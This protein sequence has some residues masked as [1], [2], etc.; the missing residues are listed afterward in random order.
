MSNESIILYDKTGNPSILSYRL[1]FSGRRSLGVTVEKGGLVKVRAPYGFP[2]S[3]IEAFL[4]EKADWLL[5]HILKQ[6]EIEAL[7]HQTEL[8]DTEKTKL[9]KRYRQAAKDYI[10]KR[11]AFFAEKMGLSYGKVFIR[12]QRSQWGS[13]SAEKNLSFNWR[14]MLSPPRIIDYVIVHE[15]SH[16][17]HM[18]HS[19]DFWKEVEKVLPDYRERDRWLKENGGLL[20]VTALDPSKL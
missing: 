9:E 7:A 4:Q 20:E 2:Q 11:V 15:L 16:L 1:A 17:L 12:S 8:V 10:P 13:C 6:E 18:N 5:K 14:L 3:D 19:R